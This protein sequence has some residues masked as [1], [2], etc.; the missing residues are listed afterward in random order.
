MQ[1]ARFPCV[2]E[3]YIYRYLGRLSDSMAQEL[4]SSAISENIEAKIVRATPVDTHIC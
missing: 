1:C 2:G 4:I 3:T